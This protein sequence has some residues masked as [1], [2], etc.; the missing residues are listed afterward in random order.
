MLEEGAGVW[1]TVTLKDQS[2]LKK[3]V[4]AGSYADANR[5]QCVTDCSA[6]DLVEEEYEDEGEDEEE[7]NA[8]EIMEEDFGEEDLEA[9]ESRD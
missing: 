4:P 2:T 3:C 1:V 5:V 8:M 9:K 7:E 6:E